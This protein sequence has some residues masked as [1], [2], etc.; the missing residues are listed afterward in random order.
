MKDLKLSL[1][2]SFKQLTGIAWTLVMKIVFK[3]LGHDENCS[4]SLQDHGMIMAENAKGN[5]C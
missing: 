4:Y 1:I 5:L 3:G 2:Y